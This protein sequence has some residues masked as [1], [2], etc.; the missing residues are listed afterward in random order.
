MIPEEKGFLLLFKQYCFCWFVIKIFKSSFLILLYF[1]FIVRSS[2]FFFL[3]N[4]SHTITN[5]Q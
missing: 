3:N 4:S 1:F 5:I 2:R